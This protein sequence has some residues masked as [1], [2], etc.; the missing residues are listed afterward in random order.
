M[1]RSVVIG[2]ELRKE[3]AKPELKKIDIEKITAKG[4]SN[5]SDSKGTAA[6]S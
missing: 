5:H 6:A 3:W 1:E 2:L 4:L